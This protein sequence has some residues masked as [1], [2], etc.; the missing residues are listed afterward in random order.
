MHSLKISIKSKYSPILYHAM[1]PEAAPNA[2]VDF[3][4]DKNKFI[5]SIKA[6]NISSLRAAANSFIKWSNMLEQLLGHI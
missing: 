1:K 6:K 3:F 5:I 4:L 2:K